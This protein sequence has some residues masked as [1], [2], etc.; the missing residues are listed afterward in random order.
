MEEKQKGGST[1][2]KAEELK[3]ELKAQIE[4]EKSNAAEDFV[5]CNRYDTEKATF[6]LGKVVAFREV[7]K[8]LEEL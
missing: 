2:K 7:S 5:I 1:P 8:I 6:V 4:S 3:Q